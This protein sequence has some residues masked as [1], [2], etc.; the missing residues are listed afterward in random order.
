MPKPPGP[1][2]VLE[3]PVL[4]SR[5]GLRVLGVLYGVAEPMCG[6]PEA[7]QSGYQSYKNGRTSNR[8]KLGLRN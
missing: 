1:Q 5:V 6:C 4:R 7:R 2:G 8:K 3:E